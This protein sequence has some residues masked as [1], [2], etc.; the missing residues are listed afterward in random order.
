M[1]YMST[2]EAA[3]R[4]GVNLR[5]VQRFLYENRIIGAKCYGRC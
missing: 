2:R 1:E 5:F 3:K 4:W